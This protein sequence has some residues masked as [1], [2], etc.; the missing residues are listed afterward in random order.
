MH[1]E[2]HNACVAYLAHAHTHTHALT[3]L[4]THTGERTGIVEWQALDESYSLTLLMDPST[5]D[6]P[7]FIGI[8]EES[9]SEQDYTDFITAAVLA[10]RLVAGDLLVAD[11]A[12][13]HFGSA[14]WQ[15]LTDLLD[16]N[17]IRYL[18]LPT[19]SPE[20]NPC[21]MVFASMKRWIRNAGS[22][23]CPSLYWRINDSL[24]QVSYSSMLAFYDEC[25]SVAARL[26]K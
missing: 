9:N 17:G 11:N 20:L 22:T 13:I 2:V 10:G 21:E 12:S 5:P 26:M 16:E 1:Q 4:H 14:T 18:F 25:T 3:Q 8:R 15:E 7:F 19:Y 24:A 23:E 6:N